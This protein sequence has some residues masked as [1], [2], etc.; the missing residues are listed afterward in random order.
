M[1]NNL[2]HTFVI[3]A[4][5]ESEFLEKCIKSVTNQ[6][7]KSRVVIATT[8]P[9]SSIKNLAKKYD[10]KIITSEH[11]DIGG[12]FDFALSSGATP[13]VTIAHQDDIYDK[14]YSAQ[15]IKAYQK[16]PKSSIIFTDYYEIRNG[17]KVSKNANLMIKR[18][19]LF[20]AKIKNPKSKFGKRNLLR[21]GNAISCPTVTFVT[22]NCPKKIFTSN[23]EC[24][25][26]WHAWETLS[27]K[28]GTFV[29][30][31]KPLMGHRIST[32]TTTT[33]IIARG[34]RTKEDYAIFKRFWPKPIA[35]LFTKLYQKSE[36]SNSLK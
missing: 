32:D 11:T 5:K 8:T 2:V 27:K 10:L 23:F 13:L 9:N 36:K 14:D 16:H 34:V 12:D 30:I 24:N 28:P 18:I 35:K 3:L 22:S 4:Y 25:V 19:L 1:E 26:D 17:K 29:Y 6:T 20:P 33:E 15:V 31:P 7:V 21:F